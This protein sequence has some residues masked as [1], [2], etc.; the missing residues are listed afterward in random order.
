MKK[1]GAAYKQRTNKLGKYLTD[2][3]TKNTRTR[4]RRGKIMSCKTDKTLPTGCGG[5]CSP[6]QPLQKGERK[7]S[8]PFW[9][10]FIHTLIFWMQKVMKKR[11]HKV[12]TERSEQSLIA[13]C[14][15]S[16]E[17]AM[18]PLFGSKETFWMTLNDDDETGK[19]CFS[20][21]FYE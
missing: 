6:V 17:F 2:K 12:A 5:F 10:H 1:R 4:A 13:S 11:R 14:W 18:C 16:Q 20:K 7:E 21:H 8:S 3:G 9:D 19:G 15:K